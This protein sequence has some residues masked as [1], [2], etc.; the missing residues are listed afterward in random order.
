[1]VGENRKQPTFLYTHFLKKHTETSCGLELIGKIRMLCKLLLRNGLK[2]VLNCQGLE[3]PTL[4]ATGVRINQLSNCDTIIS[5]TLWTIFRLITD[6]VEVH[7][8]GE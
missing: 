2:E 3:L 6:D 4:G 7:F 8:P 5:R 1:M